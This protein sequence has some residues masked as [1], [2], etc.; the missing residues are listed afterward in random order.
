MCCGTK[1]ETEIRCPDGCTY[2]ASART[3]PAA[4]VRKQ[5]DQDMAWLAPGMIGL[6]EPQQR[7]L[8]LL[9]TLTSRFRGDG[10]EAARDS[11]V[12][13]A[14]GSLAAT[15]ETASKGL[16]YEQRAGSLPAQRLAGELRSVLDE[17]GRERPSAFARD[18]AIVLRRLEQR[19]RDI[20]KLS[21]SPVGFL[22]LAGRLTRQV[23][24]QSGAGEVAGGDQG[25]REPSTPSIILP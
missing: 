8:L 10:L 12:A 9:L 13:D 14:S 17:L 1:R 19:A 2:L 24:S 20:E 22:D 5:L 25:L 23:G 11:D 21:A 7:L 15:F 6:S 18:A 4:V 16:I 3:H